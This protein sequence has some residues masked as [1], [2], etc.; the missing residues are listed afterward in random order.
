MRVTLMLLLTLT[1]LVLPSD[2]ET[3]CTSRDWPP[4]GTACDRSECLCSWTSICTDNGC[5][6]SICDDHSHPF[7][8]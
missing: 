3:T 5:H 7:G 8:H 2:A 1:F 4:G 6:C